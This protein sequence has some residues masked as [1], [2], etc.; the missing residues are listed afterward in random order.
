[1]KF[2]EPKVPESEPKNEGRKVVQKKKTLELNNNL[3]S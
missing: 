1:M 3:K 2:P